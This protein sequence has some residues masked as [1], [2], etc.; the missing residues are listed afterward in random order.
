MQPNEV[1]IQA[2]NQAFPT[3]ADLILKD[4]KYDNIMGCFYFTIHGMFVGV[5]WD[6]T[7]HT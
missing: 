5:E 6:G 4:L 3:Q 1:I 2:I 7:I